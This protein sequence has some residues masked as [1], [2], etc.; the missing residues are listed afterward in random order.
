[1][2]I[3]GFGEADSGNPVIWLPKSVVPGEVGSE[4]L[5]TYVADSTV[6]SFGLD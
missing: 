2:L 5:E 4:D 6:V 1:M 3:F